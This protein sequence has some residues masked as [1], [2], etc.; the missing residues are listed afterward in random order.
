MVKIINP[1]N[2]DHSLNI[3][4]VSLLPIIC[5]GAFFLSGCDR[6][7][8]GKSGAAA[9]A[10]RILSIDQ[11]EALFREASACADRVC[12]LST[13]SQL[14]FDWQRSPNLYRRKDR[15]TVVLAMCFDHGVDLKFFGLGTA[16]GGIELSYGDSGNFGSESF[17]QSR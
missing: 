10:V 7:P 3:R 14:N 11:R 12:T 13:L 17:W 8:C 15:G 16:E 9:Q 5:A 2:F 6:D 1:S 4:L